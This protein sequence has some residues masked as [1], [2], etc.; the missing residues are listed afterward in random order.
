MI[1]VAV[2]GQK[3][4]ARSRFALASDMLARVLDFATLE[5]LVD[6][7]AMF[8]ADILIVDESDDSFDANVISLLLS[9]HCPQT[10]TLILSSSQPTFSALENSGYSARALLAPEQHQLLTK[11]IR[12]V[13]AGEAWIP[14]SL[15]AE[16]LDR[17]V[18]SVRPSANLRPKLL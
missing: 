12:V 6:D 15:V 14:R 4:F 16:V 8:S 5:E 13:H 3:T 10:K 2:L 17:F 1:R 18:A 9:R 7:I 11:A